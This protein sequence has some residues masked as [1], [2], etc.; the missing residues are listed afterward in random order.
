[1]KILPHGEVGSSEVVAA[2][3]MNMHTALC[4]IDTK[5]NDGDYIA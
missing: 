4:S 1:M 3:W 5:V 2:T